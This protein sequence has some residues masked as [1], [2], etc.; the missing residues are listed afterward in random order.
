[1]MFSARF[2]DEGILF[3]LASQLEQVR[4]WKHLI[5]PVCA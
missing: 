1:M 2:D 4:P 5:P 3:R